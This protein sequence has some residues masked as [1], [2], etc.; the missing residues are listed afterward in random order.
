MLGVETTALYDRNEKLKDARVYVE[1]GNKGHSLDKCWT[2]IGPPPRHPKGRR[3]ERGGGGVGSREHDVKQPI[4][5]EQS[6]MLLLC[7]TN[8]TKFPDPTTAIAN[9]KRMY[10]GICKCNSP[11]ISFVLY[12]TEYCSSD[13][14]VYTSKLSLSNI[15]HGVQSMFLDTVCQTFLYLLSHFKCLFS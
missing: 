8:V 4:D 6:T 12:V 15:V 10:M 3:Q 13:C 7:F 14:L 5:D 2:V 9:E 11:L 1:C